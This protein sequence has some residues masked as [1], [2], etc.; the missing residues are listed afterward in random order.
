LNNILEQQAFLVRGFHVVNVVIV[1]GGAAG[2]SAASRARKINSDA[3]ITVFE[4]SGFVSYAPCGIPYYVEHLVDKPERLQT[5]TPEFFKKERNIDVHIHSNIENVDPSSKTIEYVQ[6]GTSNSLPWD[7]LVIAS[8]AEPIKPRIDGIELANIFT[9]KFIED[10]IRIRNAAANARSVVIV[11][12]GY[13]GVEMAEAFAQIGKKVTIVEML[14]HVLSNLDLEMSK[15]VEDKFL[16]K[17]V[18]LRLGEKV[19]E[20]AGKGSVHKAVTDRGEHEADIIVLAIGFKPNIDLARKIGLKLGVTG[21]IEVKNTMGTNLEDVYAC[22][23]CAETTH[24]VTGAKAWIPLG[25]TANKM[26]YIVGNNLFGDKLEFPGVLGTAFSK[27][28]D[29]QVA[30]TGLTETEAKDRSIQTSSAFIRAA[31][32]AHYYPGNDEIALKV[33]S[34]K[35]TG[36]LLGAQCIGRE[37]AIGRINAFAALL[38]MNAKMEDMFFTDFGY[39]PPFAPV[40]DPLVMAS[41]VIGPIY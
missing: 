2:M 4:K 6:N 30:R 21:A 11:G 27:A 16:E 22:G 37:G 41:R 13:I 33:V 5:Y 32:K 28:F 20:F 9:V 39:A 35:E 7:K 36:R 40:W 34:E 23:D 24:L 19:V 12:G 25:P 14:P 26:G 1:G 3:R 10:G 29:L 31:T 38:F 8:G 15:I 18:S 17:G